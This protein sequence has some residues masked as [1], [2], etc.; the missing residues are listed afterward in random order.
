MLNLYKN[1]KNINIKFILIVNLILTTCVLL[2][3]IIDK[4]IPL[5]GSYINNFLQS[6]IYQKNSPKFY[7]VDNEIQNKIS[8][9][10]Y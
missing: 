2:F 10:R 9:I 7:K 3:W 6:K 8:Q 1:L 5:F 4:K